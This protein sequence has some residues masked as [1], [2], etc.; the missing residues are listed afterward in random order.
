MKPH[1]LILLAFIIG[2]LASLSITYH[3]QTK[4]HLALKKQMAED[5]KSKLRELQVKRL[6]LHTVRLGWDEKS[7]EN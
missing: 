5:L 4:K 2:Y 6:I 3:L 7:D 1:L